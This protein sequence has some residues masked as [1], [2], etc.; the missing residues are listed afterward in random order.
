MPLRALKQCKRC[1]ALTREP[2]GFCE[3]H[4][5]M[6]KDYHKEYKKN[7]TDDIEQSFYKT[8]AWIKTRIIVLHR[9]KGLCQHCLKNGEVTTADMVHHIVEIKVNWLLRLTL[10]NLISLCDSC[11][12]KIPHKG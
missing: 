8:M 10:S 11:H 12:K 5:S 9:D 7:R 2:S 6:V 4:K 3:D 1:N